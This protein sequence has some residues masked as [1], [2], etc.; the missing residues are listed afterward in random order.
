MNFKI[1]AKTIDSIL[2][3]A[4]EENDV[5][6]V[7]AIAAT[8]NEI[9]Y[10]GAF[11]TKEIGKNIAIKPDSVGYIASMTKPIT[12]VAAM[13]LVER[14][15]LKLDV[16]ASEICPEL[17]NVKVLEGFDSNGLP[18]LRLPKRAITLRQLLTH[19]SGFGYEIWNDEINR[20]LQVTDTAS[21]FSSKNAAL[22]VP[23][24][25]DPGEKWIYGIS[26][27][28]VGKMVEAASGLKLGEF[29]EANL[30]SPLGMKSTSFKLT[31]SQLERLATMHKRGAAGTLEVDPFIFV[32][33][34]EFEQGGGGLYSTMQDY[35]RFMQMLLRNGEFDGN[36]VLKPETVQTMC[37]NQMGDLDV[38]ELK[39]ALPHLSNDVNFFP[40]MKQKWGLSFLINTEQTPQGRSAGSIA[41]AGLCNCYFWVDHKKDISG[42]LMTQIFPFFDHKVVN[43][44]RDFETVIY[45]FL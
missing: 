15:K 23:L 36:Q 6:G 29:M 37:Q 7:V 5:P 28:W 31:Q 27:D 43:L 30:F 33:E 20:Y 45:R 16:P 19:T 10:E 11:G 42:G 35:T 21:I 18:I 8:S 2:Q 24:L 1:H 40:E 14:G 22:T 13:Q 44:F 39:T 12:A 9:I 17:S 32:Q 41:W 25:C 26:I 3:N 4:T 34:P 38:V